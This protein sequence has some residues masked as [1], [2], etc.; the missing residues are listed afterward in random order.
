MQELFSPIFINYCGNLN[1]KIKKVAAVSGSGF[2]FMDNA[3]RAGCDVL[4]SS[5]LTH[6]KAIK[7]NKSGL[8]LIEMSHF[9]T[10]KYFASITKDILTKEFNV[11]VIENTYEN[12]PFFK[13]KG[14]EL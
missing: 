3:V 1:K 2:S 7:A 6:S 12:N 5:E 10:E 11:P 8:C 13:Y 9:D 4:I 14:G